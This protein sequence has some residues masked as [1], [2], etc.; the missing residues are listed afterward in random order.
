MALKDKFSEFGK[1]ISGSFKADEKKAQFYVNIVIIILLN[2]A[3]AAF[4][5]RIDL[6]RNDT[7]SLSKR[8][9][10]IV[11]GLD[12]KLKIKVF[13][14][15]DLPAEHAAVSRYLKDL[16]EEYDYY[17]NRNFSYEVVEGDKLEVQAQEY[18][19][20]PI[21]SREFGN[22]QL[23]M[24]SVYMGVVIQHADLIEKIN[25]LTTTVG[26]EHEITSRIAKMTGKIDAL[27]KMKEPITLTLYL[28]SRLRELPIDGITKVE[29][30]VKGAVAKS[31]LRNYGKIEFRVI[32]TLTA[33]KPAELAAKFGIAR[34]QWG[35]V[36]GR[37][38]RTVPAGEGLFGIVVQGNGKFRKIDLDVVPTIFGTN[39]IN[40]LD[41]MDDRI[42]TAVSGILNVSARI[43]YVRGHGIPEL[44]DRRTAEGAGLFSD[45]ISDMYEPVEIDLASGNIPDDISLLIINGPTE[46]L[47]EIEK[48]RVDQFLMQGKSVLLFVNSF[49]EINNRQ[50]Q[51]M[52]GQPMVVPVN[53]GLDDMLA[54]YGVKVNKS[55]VLDR[56]CTKVNLGNMISDYPLM[57]LVVKK[58]LN[59]KSVITRY[60]NSALFFKSSPVEIDS[61]IKD[62]GTA[63]EVLVSTSPE[64][65][66]MEGRINFNPMFMTPPPADKFKSSDVAVILSG[67]FESFYRGKDVPAD[68]GSKRRGTLTSEKRLESTIGSGSS[69]LLVVGTSDITSSGFINHS[70]RILAGTGS[71]EAFSNDILLHS[72]IDYLAGNLYVPEMKSKSLDYNPL[73]R[74]GDNTR[75]M[76]K[77]IN[78]G[79]VPLFVI[80]TGF[81]V[82]RRRLSRRRSIEKIFGGADSV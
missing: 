49:L 53:N 24:R 47:A 75:F 12:E 44:S 7:Y 62:K 66:L 32:D 78:I 69:R 6:T 74:T 48:F 46:P 81:I 51:L 11:S 20:T 50:M 63:A 79:L 40:G 17:G 31:N 27:L 34:L 8:S 16:L 28:D 43:G 23:K 73:I 14:S 70:R 55:V 2:V 13:F 67:K 35:A 19:I 64:S 9:K 45:I 82:W 25:S 68:K 80:I 39:V 36:R 57:P 37:S 22:D 10:E 77:V 15:E 21:Q 29:D 61:S 76:L 72:M 30:L 58:G 41:K 4:T 52:G 3:A 33:E 1:K 42:N 56:S 59:R 38:G 18:G 71:G 54:S 5:L 26:L 60:I 65:W